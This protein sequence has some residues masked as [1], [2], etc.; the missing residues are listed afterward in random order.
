[1]KKLLIAAGFCALFATP[2]LAGEPVKLSL[3]QMDRVTAGGVCIGCAN[4]AI[5]T[6]LNL[7]LSKFSKVKQR[8]V[9]VVV[10]SIN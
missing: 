7:N 5:L 1:M 2:G 4:V 8:N 10:Q 3:T 6:Q 9:A